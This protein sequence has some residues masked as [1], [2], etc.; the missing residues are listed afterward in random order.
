[1]WASLPPELISEIFEI[2]VD[3]LTIQPE[4]LSHINRVL[5][6]VALGTPRLWNHIYYEGVCDLERCEAFLGRS[7]QAPLT[8]ELNLSPLHNDQCN[9]Q[10]FATLID[11]HW[12]RVR[13]L[14]LA[15]YDGETPQTTWRRP[16][17]EEQEGGAPG[18]DDIYS[19]MSAFYDF[20][21]FESGVSI[22]L[23]IVNGSYRDWG[24]RESQDDFLRTLEGMPHL[25]TLTLTTRLEVLANPIHQR[26]R[27]KLGSVRTIRM[28]GY[29]LCLL[30]RLET[31]R[32]RSIHLD[33]YREGAGSEQF[34]HFLTWLRAN[35]ETLETI[36][37]VNAQGTDLSTP[38]P[39][40]NMHPELITLPSLTRLNATTDPWSMAILLRAVRAPALTEVSLGLHPDV[41]HTTITSFFEAASSSLQVV[42]LL[43][44]LAARP[45]RDVEPDYPIS[46]PRIVFPELRSFVSELYIGGSVI[47]VTR[48]APKLEILMLS[49]PQALINWNDPVSSLIRNLFSF[50]PNL[51]LC[52]DERWSSHSLYLRCKLQACRP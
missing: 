42:R 2:C 38:Q 18:R 4:T 10:K 21:T 33:M 32:I 24:S 43:Q 44:G 40:G 3:G 23:W 39:E 46:S 19:S 12:V 51:M 8:L 26:E 30:A 50:V 41:E 25:Y 31:P 27:K 11:P 29:S 7:G 37:I 49:G 5:R 35:P 45:F 9:V 1:M 28:R 22:L 34:Q 15:P 20:V 14:R 13:D 52:T 17:E 16:E 47:G 6:Q 48:A 36:D